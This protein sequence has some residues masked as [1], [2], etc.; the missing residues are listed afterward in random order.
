MHKWYDPRAFD[1][2]S[3]GQIMAQRARS[4]VCVVNHDCGGKHDEEKGQQ[5]QRGDDGDKRHSESC[6]KGGW[7]TGPPFQRIAVL[8]SKSV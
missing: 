1:L 8:E 5:Q 4:K 6:A 2:L 3:H 7:L